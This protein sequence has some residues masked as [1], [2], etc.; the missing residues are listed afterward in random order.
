MKAWSSVSSPHAS[1]TRT[2]ER[3]CDGQRDRDGRG[4]VAVLVAI[5]TVLLFTMAA[6]TVDLSNAFV[7]KRDVQRQA[8]FARRSPA[9]R[10][11]ARRSR[12]PSPLT[13]S[14]LWSTR[15]TARAT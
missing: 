13:L 2:R 1:R 14:T 15:S 12:G 9:A 7:R 3:A 6:F 11:S 5:M 8:D 10:S 4:A